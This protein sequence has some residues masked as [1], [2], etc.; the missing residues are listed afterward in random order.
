MD[1]WVHSLGEAQV[2]TALD[3]LWRYWQV[4][5][6]DGD[7]D[8]TFFTA[9]LGSN[10]STRMKFGLCNAPATFQRALDSILSG[11][12]WKKCLPYIDEVVMFFKNTRHHVKNVNTVQ[13]LLRQAEVTKTIQMSLLSEENG[14]SWPYNHAW[15][16]SFCLQ[17]RWCNQDR[18]LPNSKDNEEIFFRCMYCVN[19]S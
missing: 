10:R 7:K 13:A 11:A 8:K 12:W 16:L 3:I 17:G 6:E 19:N 5:I 4:R 9:H 15:L 2:L 1:D 14:I 18:C